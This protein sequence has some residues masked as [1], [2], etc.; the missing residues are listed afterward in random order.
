MD[1]VAGEPTTGR[2]PS[3]MFHL[4]FDG[5]G[6]IYD[7]DYNFGHFAHIVIKNST[8]TNNIADRITDPNNGINIRGIAE[9]RGA[10]QGFSIK[11]ASVKELFPE[12][13]NSN[14]GKELFSEKPEGRGRRRQRADDFH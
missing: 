2:L 11:G 3:G 5:T 6:D 10:N 9:K 1:Q 14:A 12:K 8:I 7:F 13:F 4:S